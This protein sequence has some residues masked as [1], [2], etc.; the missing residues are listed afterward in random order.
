MVKLFCPISHIKFRLNWRQRQLM[1]NITMHVMCQN[2]YYMPIHKLLHLQSVYIPRSVCREMYFLQI[3]IQA[4]TDLSS[5]K[6]HPD[7]A[8]EN[9]IFLVDI[10]AATISLDIKISTSSSISASV[11]WRQK[12]NILNNQ[13]DILLCLKIQKNNTLKHIYSI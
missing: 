7:C 1:F 6:S 3:T 11:S 9:V 5:L 13:F 4:L 2:V 10:C 12:Y 8:R